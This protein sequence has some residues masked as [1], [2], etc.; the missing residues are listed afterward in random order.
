MEPKAGWDRYDILLP[1]DELSPAEKGLSAASE[2]EYL[3]SS[4]SAGTDV[5]PVYTQTGRKG[6]TACDSTPRQNGEHSAPLVDILGTFARHECVSGARGEQASIKLLRP[7]SSKST[8]STLSHGPVQAM[9][10]FARKALFL[11]DE[12]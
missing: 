7:S 1:C 8:L 11:R 9:I 4:P 10:V 5:T 2:T 6:D 3:E 12:L